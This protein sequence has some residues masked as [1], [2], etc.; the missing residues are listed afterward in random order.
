M[1][2]PAIT[3]FAISLA[4]LAGCSKPKPPVPVISLGIRP[5]TVL[6]KFF[7]ATE[8][9]ST[10]G[11]RWTVVSVEDK[12]VAVADFGTRKL[13]PV[14]TATTFRQP[15]HIFRSGD[16]V[17]VTDWWLR[18]TTVWSLAPAAAGTIPA[19]VQVRGTLPRARDAAGQWYLELTPPS[20]RDGSGARDSAAIVR[21]NP[22]F[23]KA[24]TVAQLAPLDL[25]EVNEDAGRRFERRLLSGIDHWGVLP[26]GTVWIARV[27]QNRVDW[28]ARDGKV[29]HG[30]P[31]PDRVL[32]VT[33]ADRQIFLHRFPQELRAS[34][35]QLPFAAV[36]PPFEDAVTGADGEVWLEKS[37]S[38]GDSVRI[39]QVVDRAGA[40]I[41]EI[42][43]PGFGR[44]LAV[45]AG[46]VL[47]T[48]PFDTGTRLLRF[49]MPAR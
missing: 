33:E 39:Y 24:D 10:G 37:R 45:S 20:R 44:I 19:A 2:H 43:F 14:G 41:Q 36:K 8:A 18:Q 46:G 26:D 25:A 47:V 15:F 22:D 32:P 11:D 7:D 27:N 4:S 42:H 29:V 30:E 31:L 13:I 28:Y 5:D 35:E 6:T 9:A 12:Q 21:A 34:A 40:L 48:E 17:F 3:I 23:S 49:R 38:V 1:S 16:S